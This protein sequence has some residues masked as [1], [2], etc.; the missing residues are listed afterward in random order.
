M[1]LRSLIAE[2]LF[3]LSYSL[4]QS[5]IDDLIEDMGYYYDENAGKERIRL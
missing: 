3:D 5:H 2:K 4:D 1:N